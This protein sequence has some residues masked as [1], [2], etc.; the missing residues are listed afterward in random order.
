MAGGTPTVP[1]MTG[2][3]AYATARAQTATNRKQ[4]IV[5]ATDG[6]P[7]DSC[8]P[9]NGGLPNT[10]DSVVQLVQAAAQSTPPVL[11]FV[12]GVGAELTALN[13]I[14]AAGGGNPTA[15]LVDTTTDIETSFA[16]ALDQIRRKA[17]DCEFAIPAPQPGLVN[18][19]SA[20]NV[21]FTDQT[22]E[23]LKFVGDESGC[24][25]AAANGWYYDNPQNPTK[26]VLCEQT[27][28]RVR[29][30]TSGEVDVVFGCAQLVP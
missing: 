16:N 7:D 6:V 14:A 21:T 3:L 17:L 24:A 11:T 4:V 29:N 12:V 5:L 1:V 2:V 18:D 8:P 25:K 10:I 28:E 15:F 27:C 13:A 19:Y 9:E 20:V 30:G 26:V 22:S 23:V